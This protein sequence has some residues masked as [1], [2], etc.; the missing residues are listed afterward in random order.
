[1]HTIYKQLNMNT[2]LK[3][4]IQSENFELILKLLKV[5]PPDYKLKKGDKLLFTPILTQSINLDIPYGRELFS[6]LTEQD[7]VLFE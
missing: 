3:S 2:I 4:A 6:Y 7:T 1:M 5:Q